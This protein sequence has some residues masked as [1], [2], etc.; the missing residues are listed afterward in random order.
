MRDGWNTYY[1]L[2]LASVIS[3]SFPAVL[4]LLSKSFRRTKERPSA[5]A[6]SHVEEARPWQ[7]LERKTNGRFFLALNSG[8]A[9]I[10]L[11]LLLIPAVGVFREVAT[12][13]SRDLLFRALTVIFLTGGL[14]IAGL[15]Y[16][17]SKGDLNW[18][19]SIGREK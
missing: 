13:G 15:L 9:L 17:G 4:I 6:S 1:L 12:S 7:D 2:L 18:L 11:G 8:I 16:A 3:L 14:M 19:R 10:V 5:S